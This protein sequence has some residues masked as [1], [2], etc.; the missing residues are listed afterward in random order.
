MPGGGA[1][2]PFVSGQLLMNAAVMLIIPA[3]LFFGNARNS[4]VY[5]LMS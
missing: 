3:E 2:T 5:K 4:S 1:P